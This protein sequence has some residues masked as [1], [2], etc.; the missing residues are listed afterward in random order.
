MIKLKEMFV[1]R[2]GGT[3][4]FLNADVDLTKITSREQIDELQL[5]YLDGRHNSPT[6]GELFD[7]YPSKDGAIV[8][9]KNEFIFPE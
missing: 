2:D 6:K 9:N 7:R 3:I 4:A 8:L 5:Y 1:H